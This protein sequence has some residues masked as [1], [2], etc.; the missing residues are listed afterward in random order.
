M[1]IALK[2]VLILAC[3]QGDGTREFHGLGVAGKEDRW[4]LKQA[5]KPV[6]D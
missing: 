2:P 4:P 5:I 1:P 3:E 6:N